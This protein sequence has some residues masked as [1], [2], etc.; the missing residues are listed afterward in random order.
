[1]SR[2]SESFARSISKTQGL[3]I[4][5]AA[6]APGRV[7]RRP[8]G[9]SQ[10]RGRSAA[11]AAWLARPAKPGA[12]LVPRADRPHRICDAILERLRKDKTKDVI[13]IAVRW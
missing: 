4:D 5:S 13:S 11:F 2:P 9:F 6:L 3:R 1:M 7:V 10:R 12:L 8:A